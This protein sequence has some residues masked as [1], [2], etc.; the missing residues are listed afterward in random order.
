MIRREEKWHKILWSRLTQAK[1]ETNWPSDSREWKTGDGGLRC[2]VRPAPRQ[3]ARVSYLSPG[4]ERPYADPLWSSFLLPLY[5]QSTKVS[6]GRHILVGSEGCVLW[7]REVCVC[8]CVCVCVCVCVSEWVSEWVGAC[9]HVCMGV[10][11]CACVW[12]SLTC[13]ESQFNVHKLEV[14]GWYMY[15]CET[16]LN[17]Y[18][19]L[20]IIL[21]A[22]MCRSLQQ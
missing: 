11:M 3:A 7:L 1:P 18:F 13:I 21:L 16:V 22:G 5:S 15:F 17:L 6:R 8:H 20:V 14:D 12:C 9:V 2:Q 10:C 19:A 4:P